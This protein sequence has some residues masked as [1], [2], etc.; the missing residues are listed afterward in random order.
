MER[1]IVGVLGP[2]YKVIE[3]RTMMEIRLLIVAQP[4]HEPALLLLLLL[5]L[6][7]RAAACC[8]CCCCL[9]LAACLLL[10]TS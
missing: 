10:T 9:L 8:C 1:E 4:C 7:L 5:L 3:T 6:L 2:Q